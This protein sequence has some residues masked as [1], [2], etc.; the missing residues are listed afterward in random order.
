MAKLLFLKDTSINQVKQTLRGTSIY[1]YPVGGGPRNVVELRG[2]VD[3]LSMQETTKNLE[4]LSQ[5][6]A[7]RLYTTIGSIV[8]DLLADAQPRVPFYAGGPRGMRSTGQ[9][10]ESGTAFLTVNGGRETKVGD[11]KRDGSIVAK[12]SAMTTTQTQ[13]NVKSIIGYVWYHRE[14]KGKDVA[15]WTHES[16]LP[17]EGYP[18]SGNRTPGQ[19]FARTPGTGPKYLELAWQENKQ[20]YM[21]MLDDSMRG[22]PTK[23]RSI[24]IITKRAEGNFGIDRVSLK[25]D[26][27]AKVGYFQSALR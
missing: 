11:G 21:R 6:L 18:S 5:A 20:R 8:I 9:L 16:L 15:I 4:V 17:E 14:D 7:F 22:F 25:R 12:P 27:I 2:R 26:R 23:L 10:R 24:G 19:F 3:E 13:G 1:E